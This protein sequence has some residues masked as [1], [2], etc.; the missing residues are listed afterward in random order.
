MINANC[1]KYLCGCIT[2]SWMLSNNILNKSDQS[3]N[4]DVKT[5]VVQWRALVKNRQEYCIDYENHTSLSNRQYLM[6]KNV[7]FLKKQSRKVSE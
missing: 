7:L 6:L 4:R 1:S 5:A 3:I 2:F